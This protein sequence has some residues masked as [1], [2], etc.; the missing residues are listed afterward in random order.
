MRDPERIDDFLE[1]VKFY[2]KRYFP[3]WRFGQL[4]DNFLCGRDPFYWEEDKFI[5]ELEKF[6][7]ENVPNVDPLWF[8]EFVPPAADT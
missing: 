4:L 1:L 2:W 7:W 8:E 3:D 6:V 5:Y